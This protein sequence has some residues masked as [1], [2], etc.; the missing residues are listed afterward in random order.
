MGISCAYKAVRADRNF[1]F[2][3]LVQIWRYTRRRDLIQAGP[4]HAPTTGR[5]WPFRVGSQL[6]RAEWPYRRAGSSHCR[7]G[8]VGSHR[9][10]LGRWAPGSFCLNG[11]QL[12]VEPEREWSCVIIEC[13][14]TWRI[15]VRR[16]G[17]IRWNRESGDHQQSPCAAVVWPVCC[18]LS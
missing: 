14:L 18:W 4:G 9:Y 10:F 2:T 13:S 5:N 17:E 1:R 11:H 7:P 6:S 3:G 15:D 8:R 16:I 12:H